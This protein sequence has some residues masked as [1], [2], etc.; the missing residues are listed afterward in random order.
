MVKVALYMYGEFRTYKQHLRH[1][2]NMLAPILKNHQ[3][4]VFILSDK[5]SYCAKSEKEIRDIFS[6]YGFT[7]AYF[8]YTEETAEE[9][10]IVDVFFH[11]IRNRNGVDNDFVPRLIYRKHVLHSKINMDID[12][13]VYC[14]LFDM[15]IDQNGS[16]KEIEQ[17]VLNNKG[18]LGSADTFFI[19]KKDPM[20]YL[21]QLPLLFKKRFVYHDMWDDPE[22]S[23]YIQ[24]MDL[25]LHKVRATYSPE[26]Q[27]I[28]HMYYGP[29]LYKNIRVDYNNHH[30]LKKEL[31]HMKHD[32]NRNKCVE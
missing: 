32:P 12:L 22:C 7:I 28:T 13:Y 25:C 21:F 19:G 29:Y 17:A 9:N 8:D 23:E 20:D 24:S 15:I 27:Y 4:Y 18:I 11:T 6:E 5:R 26:I 2:I 31:Y 1:N 16:F 30:S 14:R 3:V 10:E